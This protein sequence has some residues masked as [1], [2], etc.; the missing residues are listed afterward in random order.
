[1]NT[2]ITTFFY[3]GRMTPAPGT[4]ASIMA[5][6][7]GYLIYA[8]GGFL[9]LLATTIIIFMIGWAAISIEIRDKK[10]HDPSAIVIDVVVG[11]WV[12]LLPVFYVMEQLEL[13][14]WIFPYSVFMFI[15]LA[16]R[17]FDIWKPGP[18]GWANRMGTPLGA[19]LDNII[20]GLM[21]VTIELVFALFAYIIISNAT[22][23][24]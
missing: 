17:L 12:A 22:F 9:A 14:R 13:G 15:L 2:L 18:V 24:P 6:L 19:M 7:A 11:Q 4:W 1:M 3:I 5:L 10:G 23:V 16:F 21:V 20:A 8:T